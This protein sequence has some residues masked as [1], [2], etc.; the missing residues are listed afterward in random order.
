MF[1][2]VNEFLS[3][4]DDHPDSGKTRVILKNFYKLPKCNQWT[5][6]ILF[7]KI[8]LVAN[9][10]V[11]ASL[12]FRL[13]PCTQPRSFSLE[14]QEQ[15]W[16]KD[17]LIYLDSGALCFILFSRSEFDFPET[18]P[19]CIEV[20]KKMIFEAIS[21]IHLLSGKIHSMMIRFVLSRF[22]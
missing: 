15:S 11:F 2:C 4:C 18:C 16:E 17:L 3:N 14:M 13:Y 6:M 5:K 22:S 7:L 1:S 21:K 20:R 10:R 19:F 9:E 8:V 12:R